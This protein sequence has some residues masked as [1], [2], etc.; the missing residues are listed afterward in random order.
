[1]RQKRACFFAAMRDT[2]I[3]GLSEFLANDIRILEQLGF[4]VKLTSKPWMV[5]IDCDLYFAWHWHYSWPVLV[6]AKL[7]GKP[8]LTPGTIGATEEDLTLE[9]YSRNK[10]LRDRFSHKLLFAYADAVMSTSTVEYTFVKRLGARNLHLVHACVDVNQYTPLDLTF[11]ERK[12]RIVTVAHLK[13][14][15]VER[16]RIP[17]IIRSIP[18]VVERYPDVEFLIIG[19]S[20]EEKVSALRALAE[21][22]GV[23]SK[24]QFTGSVSREAKIHYLQ[25]SLIYLQP[26]SYEG[27]GVSIAEAMSCGLPVIVSPMGAVPEVVGDSGLYLADDSASGIANSIGNLLED[28]ML[29]KTLRDKGRARVCDLYSYERRLAAIKQIVDSLMAR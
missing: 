16:K 2:S 3:F 18:L 10:S 24:V 29:W 20:D 5:P 17:S 4:E 9:G 8:F 19:S 7:R 14:H 23:G 15:N 6:M 12:R 27:F 1:M 11:S 21:S 22:L 13:W 26:T 25:E 28:P